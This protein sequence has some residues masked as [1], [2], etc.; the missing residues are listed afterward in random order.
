MKPWDY[1]S[2]RFK[3]INLQNKKNSNH[4]NQ[5]NEHKKV[6][7]KLSNHFKSSELYEP[8][9]KVLNEKRNHFKE[10]AARK[11]TLKSHA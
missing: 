9:S 2:V 10:I 1:N 3:Y 7:K 4:L 6:N 5:T 11:F 8:Y